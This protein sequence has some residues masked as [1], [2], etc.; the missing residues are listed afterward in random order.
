M[1]GR[2][3]KQQAHARRYNKTAEPIFI[4]RIGAGLPSA[5]WWVGASREEFSQR[6]KTERERMA[7]SAFAQTQ[8]SA[9]LMLSADSK[10]QAKEI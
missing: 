1:K 3:A 8:T 4:R 5:S 10:G 2:T 9:G 6:A 7:Q